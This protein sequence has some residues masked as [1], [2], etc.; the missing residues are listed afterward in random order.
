MYESDVAK[1]LSDSGRPFS[2][3]F[4]LA[5]DVFISSNNLYSEKAFICTDTHKTVSGRTCQFWDRNFPHIPN[6]QMKNRLGVSGHNLCAVADPNDPIPFCYTTDPNKRWE[7]CDCK[8]CDRTESGSEC[9]RWD[10]SRIK[11]SLGS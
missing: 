2:L 7:H 11:Y 10:D 1:N 4:T 6:D 5:I 9:L 3:L 8:P